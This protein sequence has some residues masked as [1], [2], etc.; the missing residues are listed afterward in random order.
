MHNV[1]IHEY[2][3]LR[4]A[5][6]KVHQD[7]TC[8]RFVS[9]KD[10][11]RVV[12]NKM[13]CYYPSSGNNLLRDFGETV[14]NN[15]APKNARLFV[16]SECKTGRDTFRNSGYTIT[17][18]KTRADAIVIPDIRPDASTR[19]CN[20]VARNQNGDKLYL[21]NVEKW[22]FTP[23]DNRDLEI[24]KNFFEDEMEL[25]VD[26]TP[27]YEITI[28]FISK[29]PEWKDVLTNN[30]LNVP[31][32][33]E[34]RVNIV[35]STNVCPETLVFW[36]NINDANL[37][38]RMICTSDWAKY[39]ITILTLLVLK[40][41]PKKPGQRESTWCSYSNADFSRV[42]HNVGY[43]DYYSTYNDKTQIDY[44]RNKM[45]SKEDYEMLQA[46]IYYKLGIGPEGGL[47]KFS[48]WEKLPSCLKR[49]FQRRIALKPIS[50]PMDMGCGN[51]AEF[52][53]E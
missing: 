9:Y 40:D 8:D 7:G 22:G 33:E 18:D 27:V 45:I 11:R 31:Y 50:L 38:V 26:D 36:E 19:T 23:L 35:A 14:L 41:V 4:T 21:I 6:V 34:S 49:L 30:M 42:L 44:L 24:A 20:M 48:E 43:Q 12:K 3:E 15:Q 13:A 39:P 17:I 2:E 51:I 5:S 29:C 16:S 52:V 47:A 28:T 10:N 53:K 1:V 46:Y 32:I 25:I 37:F